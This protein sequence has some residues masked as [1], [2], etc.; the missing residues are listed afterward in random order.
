[1]TKRSPNLAALARALATAIAAVAL[2]GLVSAG[3]AVAAPNQAPVN[4]VPGTQSMAEDGT[5]VFSTA[6][7][8]AIS[9]SDPDAGTNNIQVTL[10]ANFGTVTLP[11]TSGLAFSTGDGTDDTIMT[12][13]GAFPTVNARLD[14]LQFDPTAEHNDINGLGTSTL[15]ITTDDL[16]STGDGGPLTDGPDMVTI[17][18]SAVNDAPVIS[19]PTGVGTYKNHDRVL[20]TTNGNS[21]SV[22]DN[23]G[24][25][26][27]PTLAIGLTATHGTI[28]LG[29]TIGLSFSAGDGIG[30]AT[31]TFQAT[32]GNVAT[33][34]NNLTFSPEADYIGAATIA[35][36]AN[37]LGNTGPGGP[38]SDSDLAT[39]RVDA[40]E[41]SVYW[42]ASKPTGVAPTG[43]IAHAELD[44][45]GGANLIT[46]QTITQDTPAGVAIDVVDERIY[47][48]ITP[49][50]DPSSSRIYSAKLDGSDVQLFL[51]T[52]TA[53]AGTKLTSAPGTLV[54][55]AVARRVYWANSDN[56]TTN[57]RGIY[58]AN[59]DTPS[60]GGA[61]ATAASPP[62]GATV[63]NVRGIALDPDNDRVY[64]TNRD[65]PNIPGDQQSIAFASL[66]GAGSSG[67]F[68]ISGL[69]ANDDLESPS[70]IAVDLS[71]SRLFWAN[72][73]GP[74]GTPTQRLK[75]A[76]LNGTT[77]IDASAF[78]IGSASGGG[79]KG[80][81]LDPLANRIYWTNSSSGGKVS[82]AAL[83]GSGNDSA[84][85]STGT[86]NS[87]SADGVALLKRPAPLTAPQISGTPAVGQT[88]TCG[89]ATW[90]ADL[91]SGAL[92][93]MPKSTAF[94]QWTRDGAAIAGANGATYTPTAAGEY[95]CT[96]TATN[97]AGTTTS[98]S[99]AVSVQ[100]TAIAPSV[101]ISKVVARKDGGV[102]VT[103]SVPDAGTVKIAQK[104]STKRTP[105]RVRSVK[106]SA[107]GPG[108]LTLAVK[109][110]KNAKRLLATG[111]RLKARLAATFTNSS[112]SSATAEKTVKLRRKN[113]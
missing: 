107:A 74:V 64:W 93:R 11:D 98:Q 23:D 3:A 28:T 78:N 62:S 56:G 1:M 51:S 19:I 112:G 16:G 45:G 2:L 79:F 24:P 48:S 58:W 55:D 57:N 30:D 14:G 108:K 102:N 91:L 76:G 106:K 109:P 66:S 49:T 54:I 80:V 29:S 21:I 25:N 67:T 36:D 104:K 20:S 87:T 59:L 81:A 70:G 85:L 113:R 84:D 6:N 27:P 42:A 26:S 9:V 40:P 92:Y 86:A 41:D 111:K 60:V 63:A 12:F 18:V 15:T 90:A 43:A 33:A 47:W 32:L 50:T 39:I 82:F 69:A 96:R 52:A 89:E 53:P 10:E 5:L 75:V 101:T 13:S 8:N 4:N 95:R 94:G 44:G 31:M 22:N 61:I 83:D 46:G 37:D 34:L 7:G 105:T 65:A 99:A 110:S 17:N 35:I 68:A 38:L 77:S 100:S 71:T 72:N 97:F 88:L 103:V 73:S